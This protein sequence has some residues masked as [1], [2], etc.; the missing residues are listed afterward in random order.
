MNRE[1]GSHH[2]LAKQAE[3]EGRIILRRNKGPYGPVVTS[4]QGGLQWSLPLF[5]PHAVSFH[6]ESELDCVTS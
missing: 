3:W 2:I 5:T 4:L 6:T 1:V